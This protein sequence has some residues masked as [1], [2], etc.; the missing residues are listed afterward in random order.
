VKLNPKIGTEGLS[1][2][3]LFQKLFPDVS[4]N[5]DGAFTFYLLSHNTF[6]GKT[7]F[8]LSTIYKFMHLFCGR[9][10]KNVAA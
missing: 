2:S 5:L 3:F 6:P 9:T 10:A 8:Y 7:I 1:G 4:A